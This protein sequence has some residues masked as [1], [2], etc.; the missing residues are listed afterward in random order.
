MIYEFKM[1]EWKGI[2]EDE[3]AFIYEFLSWN[4]Q[5]DT[6][7]GV[8][9][10]LRGAETFRAKVGVLVCSSTWMLETRKISVLYHPIV[11]SPR[12]SFLE[13]R[14]SRK[15]AQQAISPGASKHVEYPL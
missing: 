6:P 2:P 14:H 9:F 1:K 3:S 10:N 15:Q 7:K 8:D 5:R 11:I 13:L 12:P 4:E